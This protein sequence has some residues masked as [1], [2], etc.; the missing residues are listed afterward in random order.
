MKTH[1]SEQLR[2]LEAAVERHATGLDMAANLD[3]ITHS[4]DKLLKVCIHQVAVLF[5]QLFD[6]SKTIQSNLKTIHLPSTCR[7][8]IGPCMHGGS[9]QDAGHNWKWLAACLSG[10]IFGVI[11]CGHLPAFLSVTRNHCLCTLMAWKAVFAMNTLRLDTGPEHL[12]RNL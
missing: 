7:G 9:I 1:V 12:M 3:S 4:F 5:S 11:W 8:Q 10:H 2:A 6:I